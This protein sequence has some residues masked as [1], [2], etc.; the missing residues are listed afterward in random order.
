[1]NADGCPAQYPEKRNNI[2]TQFAHSAQ[3]CNDCVQSVSLYV[4]EN[5]HGTFAGV[6]LQAEEA[7]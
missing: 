4:R 5:S 1:M 3:K 2:F 7:E 6:G